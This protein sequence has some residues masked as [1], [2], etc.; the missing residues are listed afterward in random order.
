MNLKTTY[1]LFGI[2][3]GILFIFGIALYMGDKPEDT[4]T[5]VLPSVKNP[6]A[7]IRTDQITEVEIERDKPKPAKWVFVK[8]EATGT[9]TIKEP[10]EM[11]ASSM[12]ITG[13]IDQVLRAEREK[14]TEKPAKLEDWGLKFPSLTVTLKRD[15]GKPLQIMLGDTQM[16]NVYVLSSD[17][18]Q[19]PMIVKKNRLDKVE[20][21]LAAFRERDMLTSRESDIQSISL[22]QT[23]KGKEKEKPIELVKRNERWYYTKPF[24]GDADREGDN[25]AAPAGQPPAGTQG[26]LTDLTNMR[27][28]K[29]VDFVAD[30]VS[31][32]AKYNLDDKADILKIEIKRVDEINKTTEPGEAKKDADVKTST[33][34]LLV[35]VGKKV[36]DKSNQYYARRA[37]E[38]DVVKIDAKNVDPLLKLLE[39]PEAL[40][41]RHLVRLDSFR[42]PDAINIDLKS[43]GLVMEFRHPEGGKPWQLYRGSQEEKPNEEMIKGLITI[44]TD[45]HK[46]IS[47]LDPDKSKDAELGLDKPA[48]IV[49]LWVEGL[50]KEEK[51]DESKDEKDKDDKKVEKP[52][53]KKAAKPTLKMPEKPTYRLT[54]APLKEAKATE[55]VVKREAEGEKPALLRVPVVVYERVTEGPLAYMDKTLPQFNPAALGRSDPDKDVTKLV[56]EQG[57]TTTEVTREKPDAKWKIVKPADLAGRDADPLTVSS[58]LNTLNNL[59]AVKLVTEQASKEDL[60]R[61][62]GLTTPAA[63][64]VVTVT[65]D[66]KPTTYEFDFG[67]K[68][69]TSLYA[70]QSQRGTIFTVDESTLAGFKDPILDKTVLHFDPTK[71]TGLTL[72]GWSKIVGDPLTIKLEHKDGKEWVGRKDLDQTKVNNLVRDLSDLRAEKFLAHK[73]QPKPEQELDAAKGGLRIEIKVEG[74]KEPLVL[75]L[76]KAETDGYVATCSK[77]AGDIFL[78]PKTLFDG[79]MSKPAYFNP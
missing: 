2:L 40:R 44:L 19:E 79:V 61:K 3:A 62:Y 58:L 53:E 1:I 37:G 60:D 10:R 48:A 66:G 35:G 63:R 31:D 30:N 43:S 12:A 22:S 50:V 27:V 16:S 9:W 69:G 73:S 33:I 57:G 18:G 4:S 5:L 7:P 52:E 23:D 24:S 34:T 8:D 56:Y 36:D 67:K 72:T 26:L 65:K 71:V 45:R 20:Q 15:K 49:S 76:G 39:Q 21:D 25:N 78:V 68:D 75:T 29:D 13:L 38:K 42:Q 32:L 11:R 59:R 54:F 77:L 74:E 51:K 6:L 55:V 17:R 46:D 14:T 64:A 47:F 70:K 41:D 28:D